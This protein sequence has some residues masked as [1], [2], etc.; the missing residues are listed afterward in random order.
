MGI[1][2]IFIMSNLYSITEF[3]AVIGFQSIV[4]IVK[5]PEKIPNWSS[6]IAPFSF[7]IWIAVFITVIM[8]G[9]ALHKVLERDFALQDIEVFW[10]RNFLQPLNFGYAGINLDSI[11]TF[12]SRFLIG[13][14]WLSIVIL[15]SSYSGTLMS[16][17]T[18]PVT[19]KVPK[20]FEEL[21]NSILTGGYS[22]GI[23]NRAAVWQTIRNSKLK[24]ANI[25]T[26]HIMQNDN[27]I[28]LSK[29][30]ERVKNE[31]FA[32]ILTDYAFK[33]ILSKDLDNFVFS[34]DKFFTY[35]MAY[36]MRNS[37]PFRHQIYRM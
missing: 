29:G 12:P 30:I 36:A 19:E 14:W 24:S 8:F 4:F 25:I 10:P 7:M 27:F 34:N 32:L 23:A 22:C 20:T 1:I 3:S 2:P 13:I 15:A 11:K 17:M 33:K 28:E 37:F 35:M 26:D 9:L 16:F 31:R 18:Y 21:A 5:R 6:V